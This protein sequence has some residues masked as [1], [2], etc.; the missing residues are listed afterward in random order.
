LKAVKPLHGTPDFLFYLI[1][2][3][4]IQ[5]AIDIPVEAPKGT[6]STIYGYA[7]VPTPSIKVDPPHQPEHPLIAL[8]RTK[9]A[10][11]LLKRMAPDGRSQSKYQ[12][13][14]EWLNVVEEN[15]RKLLPKSFKKSA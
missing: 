11:Q 9:E 8:R 5:K 2:T 1:N 3:L 7:I 6:H 13:T 4:K 15:L 14:V 10:L 12:K